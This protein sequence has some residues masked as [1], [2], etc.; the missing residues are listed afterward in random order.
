MPSE[1]DGQDD[2]W[3]DWDASRDFDDLD[4]NHSTAN[5]GVASSDELLDNAKGLIEKVSNIDTDFRCSKC[6]EP[7]IALENRKWH[8]DVDY[9][10]FRN[11][12]PD[13]QRLL[14]KTDAKH[15]TRALA[16][17]CSWEVDEVEA[18]LQLQFAKPHWF[19]KAS[20]QRE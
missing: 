2:D 19:Q 9:L 4:A 1:A 15:G 7:V 5:A 10:F 11:F 20:E 13:T 18:R 6:C 8:D 16:C 14:P 3:D 12:Y 17:Q